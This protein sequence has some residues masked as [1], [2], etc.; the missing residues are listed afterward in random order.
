MSRYAEKTQVS[1][2][3]SRAEIERTLARYGAT[4]FIYGWQDNRALV[5]FQMRGK[6]I[7]F[8][9]PLPD[10]NDPEF[11]Y[12]PARGKQRSPEQ[13]EAAYEQAVRQRWRALALVIKAKLEAVEAGITIFEEEFL[14]HIVLPDGRTAGEYMVP[15][16][17]ESY[18]TGRMPPMLP[19]LMSGDQ[20]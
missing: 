3:Q 19:Q 7:R 16:I 9:L 4:G 15:Q 18:R 2:A 14:A 20:E 8:I 1:S 5:G 17:E 11:V 6:Q 10:R 13:Q 12:T